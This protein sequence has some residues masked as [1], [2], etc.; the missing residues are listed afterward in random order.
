MYLTIVVLHDLVFGLSYQ[1][2]HYLPIFHLA[3]EEHEGIGDQCDQIGETANN[4]AFDDGFSVGVDVVEV[5]LFF[6]E[7]GEDFLE[8]PAAKAVH[9]FDEA[10][11]FDGMGPIDFEDV[12][13]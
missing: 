11:V 12:A 7:V 4:G 10:I 5:F 1:L 3:F 6:E 13:D 2:S 8:G 9:L